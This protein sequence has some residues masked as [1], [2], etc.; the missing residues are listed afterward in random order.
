M[1]S[2]ENLQ[3]RGRVFQNTYRIFFADVLF[4]WS[5]KDEVMSGA[6]F[7]KPN[8]ACLSPPTAAVYS[9]LD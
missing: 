7:S 1:H 6:I 2:N 3:I 8:Q 5:L 9:G 4:R